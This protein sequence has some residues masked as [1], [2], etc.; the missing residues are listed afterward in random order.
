MEYSYDLDPERGKNFIVRPVTEISAHQHW[1]KFLAF[2][3]DGRILVAADGDGKVILWDLESPETPRPCA[4]FS[5]GRNCLECGALNERGDTIALATDDNRISLW[6][7]ADPLHPE[8]IKKMAVNGLATSLSFDLDGEL[9]ASATLERDIVLWN[10]KR[11]SSPT[12]MAHMKPGKYRELDVG[13]TVLFSP[14]GH[15]LASAGWGESVILW[16]VADSRHPRQ[17]SNF[18]G[19]HADLGAH[20]LSFNSNGTML[21]VTKNGETAGVTEVWN[22]ADPASIARVAGI[23][24][25]Q[26]D[27]TAVAFSPNGHLLA[28]GGSQPDQVLW[29]IRRSDSPVPVDAHLPH[30]GFMASA[31]FSP[32]GGI[33]ATTHGANSDYRISLWKIQSQ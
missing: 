26:S 8:R 27:V 4:T 21:A 33:L 28:A 12:R 25:S 19:I 10:I 32:A 22:V 11:S 29:D 17:V 6:N 1:I 3:A 14:Y 31:A 20:G 2:V 18:T 9:L 24:R 23:E 5:A 7:I 15:I 16:D 30:T 13:T